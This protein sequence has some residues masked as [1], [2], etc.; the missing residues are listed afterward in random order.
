MVLDTANV[1]GGA[2]T[3]KNAHICGRFIDPRQ[4]RLSRS[5]AYALTELPIVSVGFVSTGVE[6]GVDFAA[7]AF[8]PSLSPS[9][10]APPTRAVDRGG[11]AGLM[12][13]MD[14]MNFL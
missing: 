2:T 5:Q 6:G 7:P 3:S 9:E 13:G 8:V 11:V 10:S 12:P 1:N 4:G 14:A